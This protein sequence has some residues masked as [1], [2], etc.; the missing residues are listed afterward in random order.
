M[1]LENPHRLGVPLLSGQGSQ[2]PWCWRH[3]DK[4]FTREDQDILAVLSYQLGGAIVSAKLFA[5][6][7]KTHAALRDSRRS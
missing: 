2:T 6:L 1:L 3:T 7:Q 5:E 4:P